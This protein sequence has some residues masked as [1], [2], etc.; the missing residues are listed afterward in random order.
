MVLL[1]CRL[2]CRCQ[3]LS[4]ATSS[5]RICCAQS[6]MS[7]SSMF[8][9]APSRS[10]H[11]LWTP[12]MC[13]N[14]SDPFK[15]FLCR[16]SWDWNFHVYD[17]A[18]RRW[19]CFSHFLGLIDASLP[20]RV[21]SNASP[22]HKFDEPLI[23]ILRCFVHHPQAH[24]YA[25]QVSAKLWC[26]RFLLPLRFGWDSTHALRNGGRGEGIK[27][28]GKTHIRSLYNVYGVF[29][30]AP[31]RLRSHHGHYMYQSISPHHILCERK[32]VQFLRVP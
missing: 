5:A 18:H 13:W 26:Q 29:E 7:P 25:F 8:L 27:F 10:V 19:Q 31:S 32:S 12:W 2:Q 9:A 3:T 14:T 23:H 21:A 11:R 30:W 24:W 6:T 20:L 16:Y 17:Q 22:L 4:D 28:S 15:M 1:L